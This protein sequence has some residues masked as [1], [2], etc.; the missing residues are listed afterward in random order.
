MM[1]RCG[2]KAFTFMLL[3]SIISAHDIGLPRRWLRNREARFFNPVKAVRDWFHGPSPSQ[4]D[5]LAN[6]G[7]YPVWKVH[8]YNGIS[9]KPVHVIDV[10]AL[11]QKS[12]NPPTVVNVPQPLAPP[13]NEYGPP[14]NEYSPPTNE[15]GPPTKEYGLPSSA[16]NTFEQGQQSGADGQDSAAALSALDNLG[17]LVNLL[18]NSEGGSSGGLDLSKL[19]GIAS[20]LPPEAIEKLQSILGVY[21]ARTNQE[22]INSLLGAAVAKTKL[23]AGA[24]HSLSGFVQGLIGGAGGSKDIALESGTYNNVPKGYPGKLGV[25]TTSAVVG[26]PS[27]GIPLPDLP[28]APPLPEIPI[29]EKFSS[30]LKVPPF[31]HIYLPTKFSLVKKPGKGYVSFQ[32][33]PAHSSYSPPEPAKT[34]QAPK[35][36]TF[37]QSTPSPQPPVSFNPPQQSYAPPQQSYAP[38]VDSYGVPLQASYSVPAQDSSFQASN[39]FFTHSEPSSYQQDSYNQ[40]EEFY[41]F[42]PGQNDIQSAPSNKHETIAF[43]QEQSPSYSQVA[44]QRGSQPANSILSQQPGSELAMYLDPSHPASTQNLSQEQLA[45][46]QKQRSQQQEQDQSQT[47]GGE[48]QSASDVQPLVVRAENTDNSQASKLSQHRFQP[49][50]PRT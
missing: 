50:N 28:P 44:M 26:G 48:F 46:L 23:T 29:L 31:P 27:S 35:D 13:S 45:E 24:L 5:P 14:R 6:L 49:K 16:H 9:I 19:A 33:P 36:N 42:Q 34:Y 39:D 3:I 11:P 30:D 7:K 8:K 15:Y 4:T 47:M 38:P 1:L 17:S 43:P 41:P 22:R 10:A 21:N 37:V 40:E 18:P 32:M 12:G 25:L 20:Q 2:A